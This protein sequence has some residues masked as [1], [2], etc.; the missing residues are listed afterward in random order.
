[1]RLLSFFKQIPEFDQ[2]NVND[3]IT[4]IKFNLMIAL[5]MNSTLLYNPQTKQTTEADTDMPWNTQ[6]CQLLYG[7]DTL[8]KVKKICTGLTSV[9]KYDE[10]IIQLALVIV[11]LTNGLSTINEDGSMV[12]DGM[13]VHRAQTHYVELLWKYMEATLGFEKT[14]ELYSS[15]VFCIT[16]WQTILE[17]MRYHIVRVLSPTD[18]DELLPVIKS[19]FRITP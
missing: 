6:F 15:L 10:V 9:A 19:V 7:H 5:G 16:S 8:T 14:I 4:L 1:M 11:I 12:N 2:L 18:V 3:K 17:E 13:A